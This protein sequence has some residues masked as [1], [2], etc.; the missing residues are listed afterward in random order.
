VSRLYAGSRGTG[1]MSSIVIGAHCLCRVCSG[2]GL[3]RHWR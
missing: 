2:L 1:L 3:Y